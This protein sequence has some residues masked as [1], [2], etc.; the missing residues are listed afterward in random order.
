MDF[1]RFIEGIRTEAGDFIMSL[2]THLGGETFFLALVLVFYWCISKKE[3]YRLLVTAYTGIL[4]NQFMKLMFRI[5][6]PWVLDPD[7]TIVESARADATGYSFPSGHSTNITAVAGTIFLDIK[8]RWVRLLSIL[9]IAVVLFSRMYL[10]VHTPLDVGV[11]FGIT[12][13]IAILVHRLFDYVEKEPARMYWV[14]GG[15]LG[16]S[17]V[18]LAYTCMWPFPA[19]VDIANLEHGR[20]T[21]CT[22]IGATLGFGLGYHLDRKYINF[23]EK[24]PLAAQFIKAILG[25]GILIALKSL[26]KTPLNASFG[27]YVG[28]AVR[29]FIVAAFASAIW[30]I[31]FKKIAG[32]SG[33]K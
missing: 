10:G 22:M 23:S 19:D 2:L 29:Y 18:Y 33:K 3:G 24:A 21:A 15:V 4:V 28:R 17:I 31:T 27:I 7:F 26:L 32:F 6:R 25:L 16:L 12:A 14:L 30:P 5:P 9:S 13:I 20:E 11:G 1:L 8:R